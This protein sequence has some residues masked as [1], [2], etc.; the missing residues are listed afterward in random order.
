MISITI[1]K[2]DEGLKQRLRLRAA[3]HGRSMEDEAREILK[4][5]LSSNK[6]SRENLARAIQKRF[7]SSGGLDLPMIDREPIREPV[8]VDS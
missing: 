8:E 6:T 4:G 2:L 1:R 7:A 3:Q 5:A